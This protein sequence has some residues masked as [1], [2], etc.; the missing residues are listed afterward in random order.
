[1]L[2]FSSI[3]E[4]SAMEPVAVMAGAGTV[5]VRLAGEAGQGSTLRTASSSPRLLAPPLAAG[6]PGAGDVLAC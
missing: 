4:P 3:P 6:R 1:M 2:H 5:T